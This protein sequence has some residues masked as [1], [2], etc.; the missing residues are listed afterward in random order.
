MFHSAISI[1]RQR[2]QWLAHGQG[3]PDV[4]LTPLPEDDHDE[5]QRL[6]TFS[7]PLCGGEAIDDL[8]LPL[9]HPVAVVGPT[10]DPRT[11]KR[12]YWAVRPEF[13]PWPRDHRQP[14]R[15]SISD[16]TVDSWRRA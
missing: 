10:C 6:G 3:I 4:R 14:F 8:L 7:R 11:V 1:S 2:R 12:S 5:V 15:R 13:A 16:Q 9:E